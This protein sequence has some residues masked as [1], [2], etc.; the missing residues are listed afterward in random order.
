[1]GKT[2]EQVILESLESIKSV[3]GIGKKTADMEI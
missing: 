3:K 1:M 2:E